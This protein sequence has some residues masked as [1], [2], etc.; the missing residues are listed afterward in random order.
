MSKR[1]RRFR[2]LLIRGK[3]TL[4]MTLISTVTLSITG[5][6]WIG[7]DW[8]VSRENMVQEVS[9]IARTVGQN[10]ATPILLEMP[11]DIMSGLNV[12]SFHGPI[13]HAVVFDM[14]GNRL[15]SFSPPGIQAGVTD[16]I[17][18]RE[19]SEFGKDYFSYYSPIYDH[20]EDLG[21][22]YIEADLKLLDSRRSE[23]IAIVLLVLGVA[24]GIA[25]LLANRLQ[26]VI[27][28]P[29]IEL[30]ETLRAVSR[31]KDY[32]IRAIPHARDEIGFLT[33]SFN[34]M[35]EA[36]QSRDV[37]LESNKEDLENEVEQRT[38]ELRERN[39]QLRVSMEEAR[40]AAVAK[41]QFLANMSHE[42][43]TPMNGI[44]GM[45]DLLLESDLSQQQTSYA[46]IVK[47]SA[48]TLLD[49]I[50]D[51]LDFSKIEAGKL[52]L[53]EIEFSPSKELEAV[54]GLLSGPA[55]K[56]GLDLVCLV[57]ADVPQILKGDPTRFRQ[58]VTN[59]LGNAL[60]FTIDGR[61]S[62]RLTV[63]ERGIANIKASDEA[64]SFGKASP[65]GE[66]LLR[67]EVEDSGIGIPDERRDRLFR[68]FSQIDAS[69]TR[70]FGGTGLGL[71][72]SQQLVELM[73]GEIGVESVEDEGSTFWFTVRLREADAKPALTFVLPEGMEPP[74]ILVLES[75][76]AVREVLHCQLSAWEI[77]HVVTA[78][79]QRAREALAKALQEHR[80]FSLVLLED[81][82][83]MSAMSDCLEPESNSTEHKEESPT[84]VLLSWGT[85]SGNGH[86]LRAV[87]SVLSKPVSPSRLFDVVIDASQ[88][89]FD[90]RA[91]SHNTVAKIG[92]VSVDVP[93]QKLRVLLAEDNRINQLVA[94]KIL[95]RAGYVYDLAGDGAEVLD[96]L[97]KKDYD[98]ILMD[99]QMPVMDGFEA[100]RQVRALAGAD[101]RP[102]HIVA[103]TANAMKGDRERCLQA[104]MD[105]Y[106]TKP[107][108]P[109]DLIALLDVVTRRLSDEDGSSEAA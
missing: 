66:S 103:L 68:S 27:S 32:S 83:D 28:I 36:I 15:A 5:A 62:L 26:K 58:V 20:G 97:K 38:H 76:A 13:R 61:I 106:L 109:A 75:N 67:I 12:L 94:G 60:K 44:L 49:I 4:L 24:T 18:R 73:G 9:V 53:E 69:T 91:M 52:H 102:I 100:T 2:D 41:S 45:N 59:L 82:A 34:E 22:L 108:R 90:K 48:E 89:E 101:A 17:F 87:R 43:R 35:L 80:P 10:I 71:A 93:R 14:E 40:S 39:D 63:L 104:G 96:A 70:K 33:M 1:H 54:V 51:I 29:L 23:I 107:V 37:I 105:D 99:C 95:E 79:A 7:F 31:R 21:V 11:D 47:G 77:D 46:E 50:S 65:L 86:R 81:E 74:R 3:L 25:F 57:A 84:V 8:S 19:G 30:S 56:K 6:A 98:V 85:G 92:D 78:N 55:R 72:I 42:I 16:P 88:G 64:A